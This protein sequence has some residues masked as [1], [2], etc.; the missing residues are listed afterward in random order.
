MFCSRPTHLPGSAHTK[1]I[2]TLRAYVYPD[3]IISPQTKPSCFNV[4]GIPHEV[5]VS[6][7]LENMHRA[8]NKLVLPAQHVMSLLVS[9]KFLKRLL[10]I[11]FVD[12][13]NIYIV[14]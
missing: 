2:R 4:P 8:C 9:L 10:H 5:V 13:E 12:I 3:D 11:M 7:L 6:T 1:V 14:I